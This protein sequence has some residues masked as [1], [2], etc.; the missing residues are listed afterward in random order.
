MRL[1][2]DYSLHDASIESVTIGPRREIRLA[3]NLGSARI[4]D[5]RLPEAATLRI[6]AIEN[7]EQIREFFV[8]FE[9][10]RIARIDCVTVLKGTGSMST[11]VLEIDPLGTVEVVCSKL[12]LIPNAAA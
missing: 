2:F 12:E 5:E 11:V 4:S 6:G 1:D 8:P 3:L 10:E 7:L 9:P